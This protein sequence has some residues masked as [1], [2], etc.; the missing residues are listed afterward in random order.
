VSRANPRSIG[1]KVVL[2]MALA[3]RDPID[4]VTL[5]VVNNAFVNVCREM[6]TAM[7]RTSYSVM[8]VFRFK[9]VAQPRERVPRL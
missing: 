8:V 5:A 1:R 2:Q 4:S 7:L 9:A 3:Q 6:G